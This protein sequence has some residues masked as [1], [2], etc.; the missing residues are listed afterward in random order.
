[1]REDLGTI[2]QLFESHCGDY[3]AAPTRHRARS[4]DWYSTREARIGTRLP[5]ACS[6]GVSDGIK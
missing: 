5:K 3:M 1:L 6:R 2:Q 4:S